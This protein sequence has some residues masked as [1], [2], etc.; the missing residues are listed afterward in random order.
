MRNNVFVLNT[1]TMTSKLIKCIVQDVDLKLYLVHVLRIV[2]MS[3]FVKSVMRNVC[4]STAMFTL[5]Q[6]EPLRRDRQRETSYH[7]YWRP[8]LADQ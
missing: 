2:L 5:N 4:K 6:F 7:R 3:M 8:T 1:E